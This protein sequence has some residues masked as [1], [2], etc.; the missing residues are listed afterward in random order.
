CVACAGDGECAGHPYGPRCRNGRCACRNDGTRCD[1]S[2]NRP[3]CVENN[4]GSCIGCR[5][6]DDCADNP[7][8][9]RCAANGAC[10]P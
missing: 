3:V 1:L 5:N 9:A 6:A 10:T 2:S 4:G 7:F 8:G